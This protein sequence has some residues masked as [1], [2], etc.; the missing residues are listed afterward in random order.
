MKKIL[1]LDVGDKRIGVAISDASRKIARPL[2][3]LMREAPIIE[4]ALIAEAQNIDLIIVGLPL[5]QEGRV[6]EQAKKV[7]NFMKRLN[8]AI[9]GRNLSCEI[10]SWDERF[11]SVQAEQILRGS[12]LENAERSM[13]RD[14]I[15][16]TIILQSY[17]EFINNK[18]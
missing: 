7:K 17:L 13:A 3:S 9:L 16:A 14:R 2:T 18:K 15:A 1:A 4:I 8:R 5:E 6:G 10:K 12:G 11:T